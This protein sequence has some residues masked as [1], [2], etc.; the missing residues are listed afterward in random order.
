G[1]ALA[2]WPARSSSSC[3]N[4]SSKQLVLP[5][6]MASSRASFEGYRSRRTSNVPPFLSSKVIV[7]TAPASS[8]SSLVQTSRECGVTSRYLPKK[9]QV[10]EASCPNS[11]RYLPPVR[12]SISQERRGTPLDFGAHQRMKS[13]GRVQASKT[14]RAGAAKV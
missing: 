7:V 5:E 2:L 6:A 9:V 10:L 3:S 1:P 11:R 4:C 14:R 12:T 13:S 8:P